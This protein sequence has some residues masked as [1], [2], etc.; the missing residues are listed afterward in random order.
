MQTK[1]RDFLRSEVSRLKT[2]MESTFNKLRDLKASGEKW[3]DD[4]AAKDKALSALATAQKSGSDQKL[5]GDVKKLLE[6]LREQG[7]G[8]TAPGSEESGLF[9]HRGIHEVVRR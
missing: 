9:G 3:K 4:L 5:L 1:Q 6:E 2:Q 8:A 7:L